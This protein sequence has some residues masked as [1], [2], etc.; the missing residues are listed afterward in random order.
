MSEK[1]CSCGG[2]GHYKRNLPPIT[3]EERCGGWN[4][5]KYRGDDQALILRLLRR[6]DRLEAA[7]RQLQRRPNP[8]EGGR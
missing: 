5:T 7:V 1:A 2:K 6:V 4:L 8:E 3:S